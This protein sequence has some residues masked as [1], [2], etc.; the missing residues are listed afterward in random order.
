MNKPIAGQQQVAFPKQFRIYTAM[1]TVG[2]KQRAL[3]FNPVCAMCGGIGR[4]RVDVPYG[5]P[6]FGRSILCQCREERQT[7]LRLQQRRHAA[8]LDAFRQNT[9][10]SFNDRLP[11]VQEA[12]RASTEFATDPHGWLLLLGPCGC[13]KTH[14][15]AALANQR[16]ESGTSVYFTT[17]PDL[18]DALRATM[19][20]PDRYKQL[21]ALVLE[22]GLLVLDDF[23]AQQSSPWSNEKF[24][25]ILEAR[26]KTA[27]PTVITA[28]P[29]E[30]QRIDERLRSRLSDAQLVTTVLFE[31]ATDFRPHKPA[32]A[33]RR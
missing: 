22:V 30:F 7:E 16:L 2:G 10:S 13:G 25:Q 1:E 3:A 29:R 15:S 28:I 33:R 6:A 11:G 12:F 8:H 4:L 23:G 32:T 20:S 24:L 14:L 5:D 18:L 31:H 21:Y 17:A 19:S 9:F 26:A 27:L